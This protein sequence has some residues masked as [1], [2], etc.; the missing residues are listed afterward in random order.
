ME[1]ESPPHFIRVL[2]FL[3]LS[4]VIAVTSRFHSI[5]VNGTD[6]NFLLNVP[7]NSSVIVTYFD[8][9]SGN[10]VS[11][12]ALMTEQAVQEILFS[13]DAKLTSQQA[14]INSQQAQINSQQVQSNY[15][16]TLI[17]SQ[18]TQINL[19]L[20]KYS[21][22]ES[23]L[24]I[25]GQYTSDLLSSEIS[26]S[27]YKLFEEDSVIVSSLNVEIISR[28]SKMSE[29]S[30]AIISEISQSSFADANLND[31]MSSEIFERKNIDSKLSIAFVA[32]ASSRI[33][34]DGSLA[35]NIIS[36]D[37]SFS[38]SINSEKS[39]R[40]YTDSTL[41]VIIATETSRAINKETLLANITDTTLVSTKNLSVLNSYV[42]GLIGASIICQTIPFI[43]LKYGSYSHC[44]GLANGFICTPICNNGF[45]VIGSH[46][47]VAGTWSGFSDCL[48]KPCNYYPATPSQGSVSACINQPNGTI[49]NPVCNAGYYHTSSLL[50]IL[51][52]W[53]GISDCLPKPNIIASLSMWVSADSGLDVSDGASVSQWSDQSGKGN[54]FIAGGNKPI[55]KASDGINGLPTVQFAGGSQQTLAV[56]T[57]FPA[58]VSVFYVVK[59]LGT[60]GSNSMRILTAPG[61]NWLL[62]YHTGVSNGYFQGWVY[63][64]SNSVSVAEDYFGCVI[65]GSGQDSTMWHKST[66]LASNQGGVTGPAGLGLGTYSS[67]Y[68]SYSFQI[69]EL[70]VYSSALTS[71]QVSQVQAY[72]RSKY[73]L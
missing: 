73:L 49:C 65:P 14:Q 57:N 24:N 38:V 64:P 72:L 44:A 54:H 68:P 50:C 31:S 12:S 13:R 56:N 36:T 23:K 55:Y 62:G 2:I 39:A 9:L 29:L 15:Q 59:T 33:F 35:A 6:G 63:E 47:C 28:N 51:G 67:Q 16:Q 40:I 26:R 69:S 4:N 34:I 27:E 52:N 22:L 30:I 37:F 48:P 45:N 20:E 1:N 61:N 43:T 60:A 17:N 5:T 11:S 18:Q 66:L 46:T 71:T 32:E 10:I 41:S 3:I 7:K 58:P 70:F 42:N 19:L 8:Y 25:T 53:S 21:Y